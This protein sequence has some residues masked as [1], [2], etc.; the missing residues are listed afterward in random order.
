METNGDDRLTINDVAAALGVVPKTVYSWIDKS[1][2]P[3]PP[4]VYHGTRRLYHFS[5]KYLEDARTHL[6][7]YRAK[8]N[9]GRRRRS[10]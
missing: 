4:S 9:P 2:I 6:E 5:Q 7:Q 10:A 1:I 8:E 3:E